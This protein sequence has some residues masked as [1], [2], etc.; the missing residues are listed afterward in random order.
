MEEVLPRTCITVV[1]IG[2]KYIKDYEE[3]FKPSVMAYAQKHGYDVKIFTEFLGEPKHPDCFSFQRC[4]IPSQLMDYDCVVMIDADI[5]I[6]EYSPP[7]HEL[8]TDKIGIVNEIS[9]ITPE[10]RRSIE[11]LSEPTEYHSLAGFKLQT[12]MIFNGGVMVCKPALHAEFLKNVFNKY[13]KNAPN[14]PRG[15]HYEQA[16]LGYELQTQ[17]MFS[18]LP[19]KW[20]HIYLF[21]TYTKESFN[22]PF[23]VHFAGIP[24]A[25]RRRYHLQK[26]LA[27]HG[28][29]RL[30][31]WGIK[32]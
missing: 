2:E 16:C 27:T 6:H 24:S 9:Q 13:I 29:Q 14:N 30:L 22:F 31:R 26:Y 17:N 18:L 7:I 25:S 23:F 15:L 3:T 19:N 8:V 12:D 5:Y 21:N 20:N 28:S 11:W 1:C 4:L 32:K 10:Q